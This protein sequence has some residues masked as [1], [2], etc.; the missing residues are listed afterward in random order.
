[1]IL[2]IQIIGI[3]FCLIIIY[4]TFL[5]YKRNEFNAG[6]FFGWILLFC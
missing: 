3:F 6:E 4:L 1:M 2:G 5:H